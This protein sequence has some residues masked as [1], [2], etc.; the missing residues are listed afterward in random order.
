M[1]G[2]PGENKYTRIAIIGAGLGGLLLARVLHINGIAST[3]YES[4][5]AAYARTQGGMLDIHEHDGQVALQEAELFEEFEALIHP[6]G[7]A[8]RVLDRRGNLLFE[9]PDD[10]TGGRPEVLRGELRRVL[11]ASLPANTINWAHKLKT[12]SSLS[13]GQHLLEFTNGSKVTTD[14][15]VGADGAWSKVRPVLSSARPKYAQF[16]FVETYLHECDSRHKASAEAVGS[17]SLIASSPGRG[18]FAHREPD[19]VLHA[20]VAFQ[21]PQEW[22]ES[23]DFSEP[24][25]AA[26]RLADEFAGWAPALTALLTDAD[27]APR[28]RQIFALPAAHRWEPV[29]GVTL[30]GDAAHLTAP[31]GDGA[32]LAMYDGA[33]LGR[34]IAAN[35]NNLEEAVAVYE[36]ALFPRSH[37]ASKDA[38]QVLQACF[39]TNAPNSLLDFFRSQQSPN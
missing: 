7:Q 18:F 13:N 3:V 30:L 28:A 22:V 39:G 19:G 29:A 8:T 5:A 17:G 12:V 37:A 20:Y 27:T 38:L 25:R 24:T 11:L 16:T 6:G 2:D 21:K 34:A 35:E 4:D 31:S 9:Q 33:E 32:N 14:L 10:G 15:V 1:S 36:R 26:Q 23:L